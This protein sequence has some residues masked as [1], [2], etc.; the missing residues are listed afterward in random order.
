MN[1]TVKWIA[2]QLGR[3]VDEI[4]SECENIVV[5]ND[6]V[7]M[8]VSEED[9]AHGYPQGWCTKDQWDKFVDTQNTDTQYWFD[10]ITMLEENLDSFINNEQ[11]K[12][13]SER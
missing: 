11:I 5:F 3:S 13:K 4:G 7:E 12:L 6:P 10:W 9:I 1:E 2:E 8:N